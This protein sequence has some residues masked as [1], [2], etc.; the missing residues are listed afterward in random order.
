MKTILKILI[1]GTLAHLHI[2]TFTF[3]QCPD[4][5]FSFPTI[6]CEGNS[7]CFTDLSVDASGAN[8]IAWKWYFGDGDSSTLKNPC[9]LYAASGTYPVKLTVTNDTVP[10]CSN[11]ITKSVTVIPNTVIANAGIDDSICV[12]DSIL[13][14]DA[15]TGSGGTPPYTY[16][17]TNGSSLSS[18]SIANP[19]AKPGGGITI[20][21]VTVTDTN[22]CEARETVK[23]T[24]PIPIADVVP[25]NVSICP[26][27]SLIIGGFFLGASPNFIYRWS[28][29]SSLNDS[30]LPTPIASPVVNTTYLLTV[31]DTFV[32]CQDTNSV[33]VT[34][35]TQQIIAWPDTSDICLGQS[36]RLFVAGGV[37]FQWS[38]GSSLNCDTCR[39]VLATPIDTTTY[40]VVV[41]SGSCTDTTTLFIRV[42]PVPVVDA[43]IDVT[44]CAGDSIVIGG[45]PTATGSNPPYIYSWSP[46]SPVWIDSTTVSN[47]VVH[48][49]FLIDF[50]VTVTDVNGCL[51]IDV[52]RVIVNPLPI[53]DAGMAAI[54]I[55]DSGTLI[56]GSPTAAGVAPPYTYSWTNGSS[57]DD[58]LIANPFANLITTTTYTVTVIDSNGCQN[59]DSVIVI[60]N[61]LPIVDA[62]PDISI[63]KGESSQLNAS[64]G[65]IYS[66]A[67]PTGLNNPNIQNPTAA[68]PQ[69]TTYLVLITDTNGCIGYDTITVFITLVELPDA[70]SPNGDGQNDIL[71]VRGNGVVTLDFKLFNRW[72]ELV[73]ESNDISMGWDG[74]KKWYRP[75]HRCLCLSDKSKIR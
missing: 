26:G 63:K 69:T 4:A 1:I 15:P 48:P 19:F 39:T 34:I 9:H 61:P 44:I 10:P 38:P 72:G 67:P 50:S 24:V 70:F 5:D 71:Y 43:G 22:G 46:T 3:A 62:G 27:D 7:T 32:G 52:A 33:T 35:G 41:N 56:G 11:S 57:L 37:R 60:V 51:A 16:S 6:N 14:G 36:V 30:T 31:S 28:P 23:I 54:C 47:P 2:S 73:F 49:G 53:T 12:G 74:K 66:W 17:W 18:P 59:T 75:A 65:I 29:G 55:G 21:E 45:A 42:H 68:P 13:I 40:M 25:D 8:I 64:G 58:P 20:Y